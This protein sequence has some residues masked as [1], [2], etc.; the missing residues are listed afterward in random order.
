M[1]ILI[2]SKNPGKIAGAKQAFL[3]YFNEVEIEG[4]PVD[5][6]VS[7]EPVN[8]EIYI[9]AKTRVDNLI[10]YAKENN[11]EADYFLGVESGITNSLGRWTIVNVS[12]IKNKNGEESWGNSPGFPVPDKYVDEIIKSD[13]GQVMDK[14]FDEKELRLGKGGISFLTHDKIS[15]IDLTK[16]SFIMALTKFVNGD[17]WK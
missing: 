1:K 8:E 9:G 15:R 4:I 17:I 2:G 5:S 6:G 13:L 7:D 14:I 16:E 10:K 3:E 11:I 12:V